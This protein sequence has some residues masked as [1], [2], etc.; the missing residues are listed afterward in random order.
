VSQSDDSDEDEIDG[1]DIIK[2]LGMTRIRIPAIRAATGCK[3][4][5]L[6]IISISPPL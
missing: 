4:D 6:M 3:R 5:M 1:D 2:S